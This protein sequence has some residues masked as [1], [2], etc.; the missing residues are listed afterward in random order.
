MLRA[1]FRSNPR[2]FKIRHPVLFTFAVIALTTLVQW[3]WWPYIQQGPFILFYPA[4][5]L[6][7]LLGDGLVALVL[8]TVLAKLLFFEP[9][10]SWYLPPH[11]VFFIITYVVSGIMIW[12]VGKLTRDALDRSEEAEAAN[13]KLFDDVEAARFEAESERSKLHSLFM[14]AP[15]SIN[16]YEG[17]DHRCILC[18]PEAQEAAG[19]DMTGLTLR[20]AVPESIYK[21]YVG[22]FDRVYQTGEPFIGKEIQARMRALD[23]KLEDRYYNIVIKPFHN[24]RGQII[25]ILNLSVDVTPEVLAKKAREELVAELAE[26]VQTRDEFMSIASH[27]LRTPLT[28]LKLQNQLRVRNLS[29]GNKDAFAD[30]KMQRMFNVDSLQIDRIIHLVDDMLDISRIRTGK[31]AIEREQLDLSALVRE[32]V[33]RQ[34]LQLEAADCKLEMHCEEPIEGHWDRFRIEQVIAN[35]LTNVSK[36]AKGAQVRISTRKEGNLG[37]L[38]VLDHG[39]GI[40]PENLER[41]F[42][43]FE[44]AINKNEVSGLGLGLYIAREILKL[45]GGSITVESK[46]GEGSKFTVSLPFA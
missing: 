46:L 41:I 7:S 42:E 25:G 17:P 14:Q 33:D 15:V 31:L 22:I 4:I 40:A 39:I 23:P 36:Y 35:L 29:R 34:R 20:E 16:V 9:K 26:A 10:F 43:R 11:D 45:H 30:E 28:S 37:F 18:N 19:R 5:V 1:A 8:S 13:R 24:S 3:I 32:C 6:C 12:Q 2:R 38:E 21:E 44:R 27:E